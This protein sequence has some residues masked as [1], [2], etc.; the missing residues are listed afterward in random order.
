MHLP[1]NACGMS[2][3]LACVLK[4]HS[5]FFRSMRNCYEAHEIGGGFS[6]EID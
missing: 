5:S 2:I 1:I 4:L 3:K 6:Q